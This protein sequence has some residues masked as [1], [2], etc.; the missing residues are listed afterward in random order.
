[1]HSLVLL[2]D[3][4]ESFLVQRK[5]FA[6]LA[7]PI[8]HMQNVANQKLSLVDA[9]PRVQPFENELVGLKLGVYVNFAALDEEDSI[10]LLSLLL[11]HLALLIPLFLEGVDYIMLD[12]QAQFSHVLDLLEQLEHELF[13]LV[14]ILEKISFQKKHVIGELVNEEPPVDVGETTHSIVVSGEDSGCSLAFVNQRDFSEMIACRDQL[15]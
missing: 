9:R 7:A 6:V 1:M 13:S 10:D 14:V 15:I 8:I 11:D 2:N 5:Y 4:H 12:A 3:V